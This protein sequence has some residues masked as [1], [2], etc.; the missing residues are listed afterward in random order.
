MLTHTKKFDPGKITFDPRNPRKNYEPHNML[1]H[2]K[3]I[4]THVTH[5][6][7]WPTQTT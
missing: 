7:I 5:V 1:L 4:L 2:V 3:N 6:K